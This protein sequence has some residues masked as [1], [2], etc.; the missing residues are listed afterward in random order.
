VRVPR[1]REEIF[2]T[3]PLKKVAA[4]DVVSQR[5]RGGDVRVLL[6]PVTVGS[7]TGFG[8]TLT[9]EP[10]DYISEHIHP[11]SE[12]FV[13]VIRGTVRMRVDTAYIELG[14]GESMMVPIGVRHR[15]ENNGTEEVQAVFHLAPLAPRPELGHIDTEVRDDRPAEPAP[16]VGGI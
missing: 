6:S 9:L 14:P 16:T 2:V 11:Y 15:V 13:Y 12:E 1:C 10:G 7:T 4:A 5:R 3:T 8:G